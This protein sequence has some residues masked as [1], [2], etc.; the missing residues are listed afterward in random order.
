MRGPR[1]LILPVD[2][3]AAGPSYSQS[4]SGAFFLM[5]Y[6]YSISRHTLQITHTFA[7]VE[8]LCD[9]SVR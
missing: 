4:M 7:C 2:A 8:T 5:R 3:G 9:V 1:P 6:T